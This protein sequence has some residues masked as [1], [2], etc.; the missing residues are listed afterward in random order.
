MRNVIRGLLMAGVLSSAAY[1]FQSDVQV[2]ASVNAARIGVEDELELTVSIR[3]GSGEPVLSQLDNFKVQGRSTSSQVSFV[4]GEMSSTTSYIYRLFPSAEGVFVIPPIAVSIGGVDYETEPINVTVVVGSTGSNLPVNPGPFG[5]MSPFFQRD[6]RERNLNREDA[7]LR[8]ELSKPSVYQGEALVVNYRLYSRYVPLGPQVEEDPPLTGFWVE[9]VQLSENVAKR[10]RVE[11]KEYLVFT[12]KQR[13]LFPT[14][15]GVLEIPSLVVSTAF[16][17]TSNDPFDSFF[18]RGSRPVSLRTTL[19]E[20]KVET[21]PTAGQAKTYEGAVGQYQLEAALN[22]VETKAGEPVTL[23]LTIRGAG[24]FRS[25]ESP[26][27]SYVSNFR[28]FAPKTDE[29]VVAGDTGLHGTKSWEYV[30]VPESEGSKELGP[31]SFDYFDPEE[32]TYRTAVA[33]ELRLEVLEAA[34]G[35]TETASRPDRSGEIKFFGED[36]RYLKEAPHTFGTRAQPYYGSRVFYLTIMLPVILNVGF[37]VYQKTKEGHQ[38]RVRLSRSRRATRVARKRL[39]GAEN[40]ISKGSK[41]FYEEIAV[42]LYRYVEDKWTVSASGLTVSMI[43]GLLK[44]GGISEETCSMYL[45]ILDKCEEGRFTPGERTVDE[46]K[47][48]YSQTEALITALEK[49]DR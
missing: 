14:V 19:R 1:S 12:L 3:G 27:L 38:E 22:T 11:G 16:R 18:S 42:V 48:L 34:S 30:L 35:P 44:D 8:A 31:W 49:P 6:V 24:N 17:L 36:I 9:D 45:V 40:L 23:T 15:V 29:K 43:E 2:S 5:S 33:D 32:G 41:Q 47:I 20:V 39:R 13:V 37:I 46:M 10:T 7:F 28:I 21:L 25:I 4:N 26:E